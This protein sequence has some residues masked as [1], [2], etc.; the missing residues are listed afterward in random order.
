ME[1]CPTSNLN[2]NIFEQLSDYPLRKL[3]D[4]G[5]KVTINTDNMTVSGT[6]LEKEFQKLIDTFSLTDAELQ[7]LVRNAADASFA[8]EETKSWLEQE[9]T[10]R[11]SK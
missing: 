2:T 5:V 8:N 6:T 9:L 7:I 3:M 4:A 11:F 1:L 10:K